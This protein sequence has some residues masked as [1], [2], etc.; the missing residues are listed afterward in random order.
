MGSVIATNTTGRIEMFDGT[1]D[2]KKAYLDPTTGATNL[3][4][5]KILNI[6]IHDIRALHPQPSLKANGYEVIKFPTKLTVDQLLNNTTQEG[7]AFIREAYWPEVAGLVKSRSG[8][9]HVV[10]WHF[11]VRKQVCPLS[12]RHEC[13]RVVVDSGN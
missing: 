8:A 11:S 9:A 10:P 12:D 1:T 7:K 3:N 6:T 4:P 13:L 2:G 5:K